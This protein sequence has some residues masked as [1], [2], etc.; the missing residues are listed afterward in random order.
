MAKRSITLTYLIWT[1]VF[2]LLVLSLVF[3]FA[4]K[5][6]EHAVRGEAEE[7]ARGSLDLV[8]YLLEQQAPFSSE[9]AL[10][11]WV[12]KLGSHLGFR[13][14]YIVSGRVVADSMVGSTGVP[15]MENHADR[16]EVREALAGK[17]GQDIRRSHTLGRDM[18]Y[19]ATAFSGTQGAPAGILRLALPVS[20]LQSELSHIRNTLL[21]VLAL[22]FAAGGVIAFGLARGMTKT[23]RDISGV[24]AAIGNGHYESRIHIVPTRDF[25]PLAEAINHLAE[26]IGSHVREIDERR[27]RQEAI[28]NGMAEGLAILDGNGRIQAVNR[29]LAN[30]FPKVPNLTDK[31]PLEAGMP[32]CLE[33]SLADAPPEDEGAT[34]IGR[35]EL[36]SGRVVEVTAVPLAGPK[37][38][39]PGGLIATFHDVTEVATLDRIFRDFVVDASHNLRTPLTKVRGYAETARDMLVPDEHGVIDATG[40]PAA[41]DTVIRAADTMK[42]VI[43]DL[44]AGARDRFAAVKAAAPATDA[45]AAFRQALTAST[46]LLKAKGVTARLVAAPEGSLLVRA[47]YESLV[48][49]FSAL[50][51]QTPD[52]V[53][54]AITV[55]SEENDLEFRFQGP[56]SLGLELPVN[57][58]A[59]GEGAIFL[60]GATRVVRLH[61]PGNMG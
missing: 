18:L 57:E 30:M 36:A 6:A 41:L 34:P 21:A 25:T 26:R 37:G 15:D 20:A 13:L 54:L 10:A 58:L 59:G 17:F 14:T 11:D 39:P 60:D 46:A 56:A 9:D 29:S 35:Y 43:D 61:R 22:V 23:I 19:V 24:V 2:F 16:P 52:A 51:A 40:A 32:L 48:R 45:L 38:T 27:Q 47:N 3:V 4:T 49:I 31:T 53:T 28:L 7:R 50:L 8:R 42:T 44:L 55:T 33:R 5:Q 12:D 1:W